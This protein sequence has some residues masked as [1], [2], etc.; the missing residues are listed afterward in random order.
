[1]LTLAVMHIVNDTN[2]PVFTSLQPGAYDKVRPKGLPC[3]AVFSCKAQLSKAGKIAM[4]V[5]LSAVGLVIITLGLWNVGL[6][7]RIKTTTA[8][9]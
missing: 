4:A 8:A 6:Y 9:V 1:M 2:D 3:D 7:F 5:A